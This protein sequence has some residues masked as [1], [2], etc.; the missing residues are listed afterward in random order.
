MTIRGRSTHPGTAKGQLVNAIKLAADLVASLPRDL[1]SPE[2]T[3]GREGF[4]HPAKIAG[5]AEQATVE[6]IVRDHDRDL[7]REHVALIERLAA[8]VRQQEPRAGIEIEE[9]E[10]YQN[11]E[12]GDIEQYPEVIEAAEEAVRWPGSSPSR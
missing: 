5:G 2:T 12:E 3:E 1:A 6:L 11:M 4:V 10:Q 7:M 9:E 8:Q